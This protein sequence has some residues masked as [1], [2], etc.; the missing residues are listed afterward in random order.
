MTGFVRKAVLF[1]ACAVMAA[2]TAMAGVPSPGNSTIPDC[3]MLLPGANDA[4]SNAL[5]ASYQ[6]WTA[7]IR[8]VTNTPIDNISVIIDISVTSDIKISDVQSAGTTVDCITNTIRRT[9]AGGGIVT[10]TAR[11]AGKNSLAG[12]GIGGGGFDQVAVYAGSTL[13]KNI[14]ATTPDE[15]GA[16]D[17][18]TV[19]NGCDATDGSFYIY[20]F[21]NFTATAG[22][23]DFN[24]SGA[25]DAPDGSARLDIF[26]NDATSAAPQATTYCPN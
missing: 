15:N 25:V 12:G 13:M 19:V 3:V 22:R 5:V 23:S 11:G 10:F 7:T 4:Y 26:F 18:G 8:D 20:D 14:T 17:A 6:P 2:S 1:A 24:C 21:F 16:G 9:T